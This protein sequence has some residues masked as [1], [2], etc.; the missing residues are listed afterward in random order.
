VYVCAVESS[1]DVSW[2]VGKLSARCSA[3]SILGAD[4]TGRRGR[5]RWCR[6]CHD[7]AASCFVRLPAYMRRVRI[8]LKLAGSLAIYVSR[9]KVSREK[10]NKLF[11]ICVQR[12]SRVTVSYRL[13]FSWQRDARSISMVNRCCYQH[14]YQIRNT[15][16]T[17]RKAGAC[18]EIVDCNRT[19]GTILSHFCNTKPYSLVCMYW[20]LKT[21][22]MFYC[23]SYCGNRCRQKCS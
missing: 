12:K 22:W 2:C 14:Q 3:T 21:N 11:H 23:H 17:Y 19:D 13:Y 1:C 5:L 18:T 4:V 9:R 6:R 10:G 16:L 7:K 20:R 8:W 15:K